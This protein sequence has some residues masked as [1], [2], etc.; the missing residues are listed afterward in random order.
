MWIQISFLCRILVAMDTSSQVFIQ[1][2]D[3]PR[4]VFRYLSSRSIQSQQKIHTSVNSTFCSVCLSMSGLVWKYS[5]SSE[6]DLKLSLTFFWPDETLNWPLLCEIRNS[7][8][9]EPGCLQDKRIQRLRVNVKMTLY[10]RWN[11]VKTL[12]RWRNNVVLTSCASWVCFE[13]IISSN[14][15]W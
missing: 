14:F 7:I 3:I 6:M 15:P 13:E 2:I 9:A 8:T 11:D 4:L 5:N 12:Q 1:Q 10:G